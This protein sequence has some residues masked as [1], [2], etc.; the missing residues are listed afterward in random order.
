MKTHDGLDLHVRTYGAADA[1]L[2]VVLSHCWTSDSEHW[3]Y[4]VRDLLD[5]FGHDVAILTWDH[6]G[7]G[8]SDHAPREACTIEHLARD[9]ADVIDTHAGTG[10][11]VIAGHS[12]GGMTMMEL[13]ARRP[14]ILERT[15]GAMFV[16]TS[17]GRLDSVTLGLPEMRPLVKERIPLMLAQRARVLTRRQRRKQP[18]IERMVVR[19]FLFGDRMRLRDQGLVVE[20]LINCP[21]ATMEGFYRDFMTHERTEGLK[22]FHPIPTRVLVG[23]ADLLTPPHHARRI[24]AEVNGARLMLYPGAGHMLPL[25]RSAEVSGELVEMVWSALRTTARR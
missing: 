13:A 22:A 23:E 4:Q 10:R 5:A 8:R 25:E 1:P 7:H 12:I 18:R 20:Q 3:H 19:R 24:A 14:D 2:T 15:D 9:M 16:A 6:R 17:S 11:L 21:P